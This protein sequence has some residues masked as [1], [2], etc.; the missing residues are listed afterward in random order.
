VKVTIQGAA[1]AD[2]QLAT[3]S[4]AVVLTACGRALCHQEHL[5]SVWETIAAVG[6]AMRASVT[7]YGLKDLIAN[8]EPLLVFLDP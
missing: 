1:A 2:L 8:G 5:E 7:S 3:V 4:A 6:Q